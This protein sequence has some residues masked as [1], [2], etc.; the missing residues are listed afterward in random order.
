MLIFHG[1][2]L[3]WMLW[4]HAIVQ[5][6]PWLHY[7]SY[8]VHEV[9]LASNTA[10]EW[11]N[12]SKIGKYSLNDV[13]E[14]FHICTASLRKTYVDVFN[15]YTM[16]T[17]WLHNESLVQTCDCKTSAKRNTNCYRVILVVYNY[18]IGNA[19]WSTYILLS[20]LCRC[21]P[22][23]VFHAAWKR[24]KNHIEKCSMT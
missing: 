13:M 22:T 12:E 6:T 21:R 20:Y 9:L 8:R 23:L 11:L 2:I 17:S 14:S 4:R 18:V 16:V 5:V 15:A 19:V 3:V 24:L 10:H 7:S 1:L